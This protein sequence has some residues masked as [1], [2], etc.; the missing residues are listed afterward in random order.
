M[1]RHIRFRFS[2]ILALLVLLDTA[3]S[4]VSAVP[5]LYYAPSRRALATRAGS[6]SSGLLDVVRVYE[7]VLRVELGLCRAQPRQVARP[8]V[9]PFARGVILVLGLLAVRGLVA[10]EL[11]VRTEGVRLQRRL[12]LVHPRLG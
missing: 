7:D 2:R 4:Y 10:G 1:L 3:V 6:L 12:G 9:R 11:A 5:S 8:A